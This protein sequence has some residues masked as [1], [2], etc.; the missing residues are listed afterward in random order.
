MVTNVGAPQFSVA[1]QLARQRRLSGMLGVFVVIA[2]LLACGL[3]LLLQLASAVVVATWIGVL[4]IAWRPI[5]G[6]YVALS[7]VLLFESGRA[8]DDARSLL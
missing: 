6:L 3:A 8:I 5:V 2:A 1:W 7:L 4:A